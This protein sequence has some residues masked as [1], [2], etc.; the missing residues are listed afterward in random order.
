[1]TTP[2]N[3]PE[4]TVLSFDELRLNENLLRAVR[5]EGYTTPTPIQARS[6]PPVLAGRDLLGCAQTGTGKTAAFTLPILHYLGE[7][8]KI[9]PRGTPRALI[10]APTRELAAQI[11]ESIKTYGKFTRITYA[12]VFG[13]VGMNPQ[14]QALNRGVD[15]LVAT[16][17]RLLDLMNQGFVK[18]GG[19]E[20][21]VLDEADRML[22][23]GF[24][25]DIKKVLAALPR[26]RQNLF[27]SATFSP[28]VTTLANT[29]VRDPVTVSI[30]PEQP[31]VDRITQSVYFVQRSD[32]ENLLIELL[33]NP[34]I[35][36]VVVFIQMKHV[37]N[38]LAQHLTKAGIRAEA[39]HGN[40]SQT[41]RM[42]ALH[43]FKT[44][45]VRVLVA[46]DIAARGLDIDGITHVF[47]YELPVEP[48][49][50]VHRI[51]RTARAGKDGDAVSLVCGNEKA[52]LK[53]IQRLIGFEIPVERHSNPF[54]S[55]AD[56]RASGADAR[57][58]PRGSQRSFGGSRPKRFGDKPRNQFGSSRGRPGNAGS[59]RSHGERSSGG[60]G[61][62]GGH[63]PAFKRH[64]G[65]SSHRSQGS[66]N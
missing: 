34:A 22:D 6:I 23:M 62:A 42:A 56:E 12:V 47:N 48:E 36:R 14:I 45:K 58:I 39:I 46:T 64:T 53:D 40:K 29:M 60:Y 65:G 66:R 17:G 4:N 61:G 59:G 32:K 5:E 24:I 41:A 35:N 8:K 33:K 30:T 28:D 38:K 1:M 3:H 9:L 63:K 55:D 51:G 19:I 21:F 2:R 43:A 13:G 25:H 37:A 26:A 27:F 10:L 50:Y 20:V 49:T 54:H 7:N 31:T 18:L 44:G 16:P 52:Q 57:P 15:I 11:G